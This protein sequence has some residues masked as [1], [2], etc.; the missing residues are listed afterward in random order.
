MWGAWDSDL[1]R[2]KICIPI[3]FQ[4]LATNI[5][6]KRKMFEAPRSKLRGIFDRKEVC[7]FEIRSLNPRQATGNMLAFAVQLFLPAL[8]Y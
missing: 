5:R 6:G 2:P 1:H 4:C 3:V 7:Y 8:N